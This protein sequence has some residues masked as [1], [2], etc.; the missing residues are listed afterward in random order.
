MNKAQKHIKITGILVMLLGVIHCAATPL[1]LPPKGTVNN[2]FLLTF[3]YMFICT[4]MATIFIGW[5]QYFIAKQ[6]V[7]LKETWTVLITSIFLVLVL[8]IIAVIIMHTNPFA[9]IFLFIALYELIW[10]IP[11]IKTPVFR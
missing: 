3:L 5:I 6:E 4:G 11:L 9:Y 8:G 2:D 1:I 7:L 10:L